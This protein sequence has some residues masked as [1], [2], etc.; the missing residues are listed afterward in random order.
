MRRSIFAVTFIGVL[1]GCATV[2]DGT[3][4]ALMPAPGKPF[5]PFVAEN[6][7]CRQFA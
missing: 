2:P 5:D 6:R 1:A 3:S 4:V 7:E